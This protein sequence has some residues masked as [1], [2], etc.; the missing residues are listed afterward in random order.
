MTKTISNTITFALILGLIV[1]SSA[2]AETPSSPT[3]PSQSVTAQKPAGSA[4]SSAPTPPMQN[5]PAGNPPTGSFLMGGGITAASGPGS[6]PTGAPAG[7]QPGQMTPMPN[8]L[9]KMKKIEDLKKEFQQL[10]IDIATKE[11]RVVD[12]PKEKEKIQNETGPL[13]TRRDKLKETEIPAREA[14]LE[15]AET[16]VTNWT[17]EVKKL[18]SAKPGTPAYAQLTQAKAA[19]KTAQEQRSLRMQ[20]LGKARTEY[21]TCKSKIEKADKDIEQLE[22]DRALL[23]DELPGLKFRLTEIKNALLSLGVIMPN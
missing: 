10:S 13:R 7:T 8:D 11:K 2:F 14:A 22:K 16:A 12:I 1:N 17:A 18:E 19:L 9:E 3:A 5:T 20:E 23:I 21:E 15:T 4:P 6:N